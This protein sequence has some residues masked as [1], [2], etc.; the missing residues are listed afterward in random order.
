MVNL[1]V[2]K[3]NSEDRFNRTK[4]RF[5]HYFLIIE[6]TYWSHCSILVWR[7]IKTV[8]LRVTYLFSLFCHPQGFGIVWRWQN[9]IVSSC[10][11]RKNGNDKS[12]R[13]VG[14]RT[15]DVSHDSQTLR[16]RSTRLLTCSVLTLHQSMYRD[17]ACRVF[18]NHW[19]G[20]RTEGYVRS[21]LLPVGRARVNLPSSSSLAT[22]CS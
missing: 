9:K 7:R 2:Q 3:L 15:D 11:T 17:T 6:T 4:Q 12:R 20:N 5:I 8:V 19:S 13:L 22:N 10:S 16:R 18:F 21:G 14:G 1:L